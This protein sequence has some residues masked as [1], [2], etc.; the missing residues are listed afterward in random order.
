MMMR[1]MVLLAV[2]AP[3]LFDIAWPM[4]T[5]GAAASLAAGFALRYSAAPSPNDEAALPPADDL[6][7]ALMFGGLL[8]AISLAIHFAE[9]HFGDAGLYALAAISGT[10]DVDAFTLSAARTVGQ[11][12]L[13]V[14]ARDAVLLAVA[15][16]TLVKGVL[17]Y[18][19]GGTA[20]AKRVAAVIAVSVA[21]GAAVW[22]VA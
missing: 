16:N 2:F 13:P 6:W 10:F 8:T 21:A 19:I 17:A 15:V 7:F 12:A 1:V 4:L 5:A 3:S 9:L 22:V 18:S 11:A 14:A 20:L